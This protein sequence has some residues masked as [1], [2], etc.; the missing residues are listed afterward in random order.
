VY[1][2]TGIRNRAGIARFAHEHG[3]LGDAPVA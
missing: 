3:L 2:K 1:E